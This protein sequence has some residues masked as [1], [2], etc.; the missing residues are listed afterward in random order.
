MLKTIILATSMLVAAPVFA[1]D[2]PVAKE[3]MPTQAK[4]ADNME[5]TPATDDAAPDAKAAPVAAAATPQANPAPATQAA[6]ASPAQAAPAQPPAPAEAAKPGPSQEQVAQ[7]VGRDFAKYDKDANGNLN[8]Q[9]FGV[10]MSSLRKAAE[11]AFVPGSPEATAWAAQAFTSADID[12]S[13]SVNRQ[14]L[15]VFLTPKAS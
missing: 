6:Q 10:W 3:S 12:K 9:E 14:E 7:A 2:K 1:Q 8:A 15:T 4:P 11:P 5:S 13:A